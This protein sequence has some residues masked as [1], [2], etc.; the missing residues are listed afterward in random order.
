MNPGIH[1][2]QIQFSCLIQRQI[3]SWIT[4]D[5]HS[6]ENPKTVEIMWLVK[7]VRWQM[8]TYKWALDS[9]RSRISRATLP[10]TT[11]ATGSASGWLASETDFHS[12]SFSTLDKMMRVSAACSHLRSFQSSLSRGSQ[13]TLKGKRPSQKDRKMSDAVNGK[14]RNAEHK[15]SLEVLVSQQDHVNLASPAHPAHRWR[16]K[17]GSQ[18]KWQKYSHNLSESTDTCVKEKCS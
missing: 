16:N 18:R 8:S 13:R 11:Q 5:W 4:V 17:G 12:S 6:S 7:T 14:R 1:S 9:F 2:R 10:N 15:H 3:A